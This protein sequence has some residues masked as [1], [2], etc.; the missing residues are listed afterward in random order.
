[1]GT[2]IVRIADKIHKIVEQTR[3]KNTKFGKFEG[4]G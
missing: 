1:M 3:L 2:L 4:G